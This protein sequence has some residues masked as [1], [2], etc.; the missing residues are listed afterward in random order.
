MKRL[1]VVAA[2][3]FA[4]VLGAC[5]ALAS[6]T[7]PLGIYSWTFEG[8]NGDT[9]NYYLSTQQIF[10]GAYCYPRTEVL[11]GANGG[12]TFWS[13]DDQG[14]TLFHGMI[15]QSTPSYTFYLDPPAVY[16]DPTLQPGEITTS[17]VNVY[18]V[19]TEGDLWLGNYTVDLTC[20]ARGPVTTPLGTFSAVTQWPHWIEG[21]GA[22]S[23]GANGDHSY[24]MGVG[25]V[26]IANHANPSVQWNLIGATGLDLTGAPAPAATVSLNAAPN[27][28]NPETT[29]SFR[30]AVAGPVRL[31]VFD[32]AGRRV[33][34]LID[35]D[36]AAGPHSVPWQPRN[37]GS[38]IYL[39]RLAAA[40][41][42][43][44]LRVTLVE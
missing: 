5:S 10:N 6:T 41:Q 29:L 16:V 33:A 32:L 12:I 35:G 3:T 30:L 22:W 7:F 2:M 20:I 19:R 39:A 9:W 17:S 21:V 1:A 27:P 38:G 28:F 8:T 43:R 13:E 24:G 31:E 40:D 44:T 14:R 18:Q 4:L 36:L 23:Y 37:L 25:P 42:V 26:R 11:P 15:Y 34:S